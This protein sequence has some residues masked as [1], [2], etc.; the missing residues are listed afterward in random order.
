MILK[1]LIQN[2]DFAEIKG[3]DN[4]EITSITFDSRKSTPGSLFIAIKGTVTDG[5]NFI[6]KAVENGC[7]AVV[8]ERLPEV[9]TQGVTYIVVPDSEKAVAELAKTFYGDPSKN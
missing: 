4:E 9:L 6:G 5:H 7:R 3:S 1:I 8:C 2:I